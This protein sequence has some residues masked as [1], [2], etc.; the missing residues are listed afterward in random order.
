MTSPQDLAARARDFAAAWR[1][2][3]QNAD[4]IYAI[5]RMEGPADAREHVSYV[6]S[7]T[8]LD[9]LADAVEGAYRMGYRDGH[10]DGRKIEEATA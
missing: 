8:L 10:K 5:H 4:A 9:E 7:A 2:N 1:D 3:P 6:V